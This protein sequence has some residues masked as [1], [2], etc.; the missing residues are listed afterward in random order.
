MQSVRVVLRR[1]LQVDMV[2]AEAAQR[3]GQVA[4]GQ[5]HLHRVAVSVNHPCIRVLPQHVVDVP[6]VLGRLQ[7]PGVAG[8]FPLQDLQPAGG[9]CETPRSC[10]PVSPGAGTASGKT[11]H[12]KSST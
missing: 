8:A 4:H 5:G 10:S 6:Q 7:H 9:D 2:G 1:F 11:A 3:G 12:Q